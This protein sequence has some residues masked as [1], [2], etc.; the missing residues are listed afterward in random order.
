MNSELIIA[1][2]ALAY[3]EHCKCSATSERL[4]KSICTNPVRIRKVMAALKTAGMI[5]TKEG[6]S[7]GYQLS[8]NANDITLKDVSEALHT[9]LIK[10][11][12]HSGTL[13]KTC[14]IASGM[15]EVVDD[16]T[17]ALQEQCLSYLVNISIMD[18]SEKLIA[19]ANCQ[20]KEE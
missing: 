5:T 12:W 19:L 14:M 9:P 10:A 15:S 18:I 20:Q 13:N 7:G 16:L 8:E 6:N 3:L 17:N 4:A 11:N 1:I 2:H